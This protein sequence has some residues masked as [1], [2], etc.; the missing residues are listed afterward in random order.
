[1]TKTKEYEVPYPELLPYK[2]KKRAQLEFLTYRITDPDG[3]EGI[4]ETFIREEDE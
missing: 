1:M 3:S 4:F 2:K